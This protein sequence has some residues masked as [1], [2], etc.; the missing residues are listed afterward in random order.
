[1]RSVAHDLARRDAQL[2]AQR[3]AVH[4]HRRDFRPPPVNGHTRPRITVAEHSVRVAV[5]VRD[6]EELDPDLAPQCV[7]HALV[8]DFHETYTGDIVSPVIRL[9]ARESAAY[10]ELVA[11]LDL[12]IR[13][14]LAMA[15]PTPAQAAA[16]RK[17][18][19]L[20]LEIERTACLAPSPPPPA[21]G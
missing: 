16:V 9:L 13:E 12:V 17:A 14:K 15:P 4:D 11:R 20:A 1:M 19:M 18:D 2:G 8:H 21:A 10:K 6:V 5:L 7:A 3:A